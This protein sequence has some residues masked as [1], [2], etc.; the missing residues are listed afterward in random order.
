M[1]DTRMHANLTPATQRILVAL[2]NV[3]VALKLDR[4]LELIYADRLS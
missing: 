3:D 1:L 4:Q 2:E